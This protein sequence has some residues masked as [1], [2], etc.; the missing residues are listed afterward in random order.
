MVLTSLPPKAFET[1]S[2]AINE[3]M[4]KRTEEQAQKASLRWAISTIC[5][6]KD[7]TH[8]IL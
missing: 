8:S 7:L 4:K 2:Q 6:S 3:K 5:V 1:K